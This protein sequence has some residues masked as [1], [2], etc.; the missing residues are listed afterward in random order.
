MV[1]FPV[2]TADI[3]ETMIDLAGIKSDFVRFA[4]SLLPVLKH[5]TN[6]AKE[7]ETEQE[8]MSRFVYSEGGFY[9]HSELFPGGSD[10]VPNDPKGMFN[11]LLIFFYIMFVTN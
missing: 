6:N 8:N 2:Q 4:K 11:H 10:H 9:F 3:M 1:Q 5:N 7:T